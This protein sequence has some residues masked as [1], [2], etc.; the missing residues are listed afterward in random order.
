[1]QLAAVELLPSF[2]AQHPTIRLVIVDSVTFHFR[3]VCLACRTAVQRP[4]AMGPQVWM[5]TATLVT[6]SMAGAACIWLPSRFGP[7]LPRLNC[8]LATPTNR[9]LLAWA[10]EYGDMAAR[11]RQLAQMAQQLMQLAGERDVAVGAGAW[12]GSCCRSSGMHDAPC[13]AI[14]MPSPCHAMPCP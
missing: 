3:Q 1:M 6:T 7:S 5:I 13:H 14:A 8:R 11:T 2:L 9:P 4:L 12:A 10:Q